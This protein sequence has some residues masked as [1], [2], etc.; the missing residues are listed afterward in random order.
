MNEKTISS[1]AGL[2]FLMFSL[3]LTV[4]STVISSTSPITSAL[5]ANSSLILDVFIVIL[6]LYL[7]STIEKSP[8]YKL[9]IIILL[10]LLL[11]LEVYFRNIRWLSILINILNFLIRGYL[12]LEF[13]QYEWKSTKDLDILKVFESSIKKKEE[14]PKKKEEPKKEE[15]KKEEPKKEEP[16]KEEESMSEKNRQKFRDIIN[17][18]GK[19]NLIKSS[20]EDGFKII[21]KYKETDELTMERV[22]EAVSKLRYSD[23]NEVKWSEVS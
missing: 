13:V 2:L 16:K 11:I 20:R 10:I 15:P 17:K 7:V 4:Y 22:K 21:D 5:M 12:I 18:I 9:N 23:G 8:N 19:E 6:L 3:F 14:P 1:G